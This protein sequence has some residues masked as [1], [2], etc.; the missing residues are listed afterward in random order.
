MLFK[1][2]NL[3]FHQ[4]KDGFISQKSGEINAIVLTTKIKIPLH[5]AIAMPVY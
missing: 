4:D 3:L 2:T 1:T 5:L